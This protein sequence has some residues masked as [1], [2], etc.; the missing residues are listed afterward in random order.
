MKI[1]K[2]T[3]IQEAKT[4]V[5]YIQH[6][7]STKEAIEHTKHYITNTLTAR[8]KEVEEIVKNATVYTGGGSVEEKDHRINKAELLSALNNK[9]YE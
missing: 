5:W 6:A 2:Q 9:A 7:N 8:D 3:I 4:L 1:G